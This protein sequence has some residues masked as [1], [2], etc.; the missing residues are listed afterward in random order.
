MNIQKELSKAIQDAQSLELTKVH[1]EKLEIRLDQSYDQL[2]VLH[3]ILEKEYEDVRLLEELSMKSL[4]QKILGNSEKQLEKERQEYLEA[5]LKYNEYKKTV[6]LIEYE[7]EILERKLKNYQIVKSKLNSLIRLR[8][9]ELLQSEEVAR[10]QLKSINN[11]IDTNLRLKRELHEAVLVGLKIY[12][13]L[14]NMEDQLN[15]ATKWGDWSNAYDPSPEAR[16]LNIDNATKLS[17]QAKELLIQF[18]SELND[19]FSKK[20]LSWTYDLKDAEK[21][22]NL[23]FKNL[24][25]DWVVQQKLKTTLHHTTNFK[26]KIY[27]IN[28]S[29]QLELKQTTGAIKYLENKKRKLI[30]ALNEQEG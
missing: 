14:K 11:V 2:E 21:F 19:V 7:K 1:L 6:E 20:P 24:I 26:N 12:E 15:N 3:D 9:R 29:L 5:A 8:E 27:R 16:D 17:Y 23:Y 28:A 10:F 25:S 22:T 18:E 30:L 13:I 4:F